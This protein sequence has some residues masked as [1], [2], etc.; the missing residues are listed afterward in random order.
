MSVQPATE[1]PR[2][3]RVRRA[4]LD[5]FDAADLDMNGLAVLGGPAN[6]IMQLAVPAVGYGVY[7]SKVESG[8]LFKHPIKRTRTT[9]SYLAVAGMGSPKVRRAYR[10]AVNTAHVQVRSS[11]ESPVEYNAFDAKLQL[12]VAACLYKGWEDVERLYGDPA[13]ITEE[14]YRQGAVFG[15]TLQMPL[16]MWPAT[17][18]DFE[19]YWQSTIAELEIDETIRGFLHSIS[20]G[21]FAGPVVSKLT[22]WY[23]QLMTI[24]FLPQEFR[25]K[26]D[27]QFTP[28]Q[29]RAF[30]AHN[31][32]ARFV[33]QRTPA[34]IQRLP[35]TL[36][37]ADVRWRM[38]TGRPLV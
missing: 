15:T 6:V 5:A 26:M 13:N 31:A 27:L 23:L 22:G 21:E 3:E 35:F 24:G 18:A 34:V 7:E 10:K 36:L 25:D 2:S 28:A 8:A 33:S 17:R 30:K 12:W 11:D 37:L 19:E 9:L 20:R 1:P 29:E 38:R 14:R 16:E 4:E 32:V